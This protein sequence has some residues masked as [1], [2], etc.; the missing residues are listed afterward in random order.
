VSSKADDFDVRYRAVGEA[1]HGR[2]GAS[3]GYGGTVD[4]DLGYDAQGF[5]TDGFRS[6]EADYLDSHQP[7]YASGIGGGIGTAVRPDHGR[8]VRGRREGS[9]ARAAGTV[10]GTEETS[11][12]RRESAITAGIRPPGGP[13]A[14]QGPGRRGPRR[15]R[16]KVKGSWWRRWTV[17]KVLGLLLSA[18]GA[19]IVLSAIAVVVA[20][21]QTPVPTEAMAATGFAQSVVYSGNGTLIGRFG[22][23]NR[24]MLTYS[25]IPPT[26]INAVLAAED[27]NFF[28]EGG[29][30]PTGIVRA[31]YQDLR[32]NNGSLQG[33]STI[34]QEFVRQYYLGIGTQ[35]TFS[36]KIKEIFVAMKVAKEKSKPWILTNYLNTI[37]LGDGAYG[38]EAAAQTYYGKP[39]AKLDVAQAAVIAAIIQQP[40]S[41]PLPEFHARLVHRWHY[42]LNGMVQMGNL[43]AQRAAAMKFPAPGEYVPQSVGTDVWDPYVLNMVYN[44]L[45]DVYHFSPSQIYN[46]GYVIRTTIDNAKMAALYQTVRDNEAQMDASSVPFDPTYMHAGAVLE[47]PATGAIQALYPGPGYPG[48]KYNGTGRVITKRYCKKIAC[49][50]NMAVYNREQVGSSFKP[51]ILS[52]A[53]KQDMNVQTSTLDG[54]NNVYIPLDSQ[55][56]MYPASSSSAAQAGWYLVHNDSM[57]E[58]GPYTPQIA[59]AV[60]INTAYADLWHVVAGQDGKNV[61]DMAQAFGVNTDAAGFP[62]MSNQA[63]VALGQASLTVGEQ[64]TMLATIDNGGVYHNAHVISSIRQNNA[65]P[66]PIKITSYP[67]FS[68]D[69]TLN[70]ERASQVQYAMSVDT[71][72]YGTA[73]TAGMSNGQEI[74]AKTGTTNTAQSAFFIGAIPSQSLAVALFT[75]EQGKGAQT[76]NNLGGNPQGGFGGTW[77]ATIW[78][79]YAENEFVPLGVQQFT[80]P[81]FTGST[82]N[83]VPP[84]LRKVPKKHKKPNHGRP[85]DFPTGQPSQGG[86]NPN[87]FPTFSC[88]PT[89]VTCGGGGGGGGGGNG[90]SVNATPAGAAVGG[91]VAGLPA[92]ALRARRRRRKR[93][94]EDRVR[95]GGGRPRVNG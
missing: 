11:Q 87:P 29:V 90:Q 45:V 33:G 34:T 60:S 79:T 27:R 89:V 51:Y 31:A 58:N 81:V 2:A 12:L 39:V 6:P 48:S 44:E 53:V 62:N 21:E 64:A 17:R 23:T 38:I 10:A 43:T 77:P 7:D 13:V 82:W 71:A 69:P 75:N 63:G 49:E 66:T 76:L 37:Y 8:T 5:D 18:I 42:V 80:Q 28:N 41:Y 93:R 4:Y 14:L 47:D 55:P 59:M 91:I 22:T 46:G 57:A 67:V 9:H 70:S 50:V 40:S 61:V 3:G 36:R 52:T 68:S 73:P 88:D 20:Y 32:G 72:P 15:T 95:Y 30:S 54:Y 94:A 65:P 25:Q 84:G 19:V 1:G 26:I 56:T 16:V 74:I 24:Q 35:Q 86:G 78:H 92:T 83:L 85:N